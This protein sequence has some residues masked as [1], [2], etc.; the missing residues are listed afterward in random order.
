MERIEGKYLKYI[1]KQM[2]GGKKALLSLQNKF[3]ENTHWFALKA[4]IPYFIDFADINQH[5]LFIKIIET[6]I[7]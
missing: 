3:L 5:H 6:V 2:I 1:S 4:N 7:K